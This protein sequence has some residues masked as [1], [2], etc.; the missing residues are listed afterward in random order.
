LKVNLTDKE[1]VLQ[2]TSTWKPPQLPAEVGNHLVLVA[3]DKVRS[4]LPSI[5]DF[6]EARVVTLLE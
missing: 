4:A 6:R 3:G 5:L 2:F 1:F